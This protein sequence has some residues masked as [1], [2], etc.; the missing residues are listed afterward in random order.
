MTSPSDS[1]LRDHRDF[2][3]L[4]VEAKVRI[5][6]VGAG[7]Q[8]H[9]PAEISDLSLGGARLATPAELQ[10]DQEIRLIPVTSTAY[11]HPLYKP[12]VYTVVWQTASDGWQS[13]D[14]EWDYYGL[15]HQ[16]SV[17]DILESWV[18]HLLL[19]RYK[20][21]ELVVQRRQHRRLKLPES[22]VGPVR[23][24]ITHDQSLC[25]LTLID[26]APG[27]LLARAEATLAVGVHLCFHDG[28]PLGEALGTPAQEPFFASP[29]HGCVIDSH[30]HLGSTF[31]RVSFD[32]D[33]EVDEDRILDWASRWGGTFE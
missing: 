13:S 26:V 19:R 14:N 16:G 8:P 17:L 30:A 11:E 1:H 4:N 15:R 25:D 33:S 12:L 6:G 31:Y 21:E 7:D 2:P 24:T 32:P 20:D 28:L 3:R 23:A 5:E 27:G 9:A 10:L 18:G 22:G 29:V